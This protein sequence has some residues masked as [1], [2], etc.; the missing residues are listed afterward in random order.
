MQDEF[1]TGRLDAGAEGLKVGELL[2]PVLGIAEGRVMQHD[3]AAEAAIAE[4]DQL[5]L[6]RSHLPFADGATGEAGRCG[7]GSGNADQRDVA[8]QPDEGE[9]VVAL[10]RRFD[11]AAV[12]QIR[13]GHVG[14]PLTDGL[15]PIQRDIGVVIAGYDRDLVGRAEAADP[16]CCV[17]ELA[18]ERDVDDVAGHRDVV[19]RGGGH[20]LGQGLEDWCHIEVLPVQ[21]PGQE[22]K[23]A[24]VQQLADAAVRQRSD[25]GIRQMRQCEHFASRA[26]SLYMPPF[27][28]P[29][30]AGVK[31]S[32]IR[33]RVRVAG[34]FL[35]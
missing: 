19:G 12:A 30:A 27:M 2:A 10:E 24:L 21:G 5:L 33:S 23:D 28:W 4:R 6:Q 7:A 14:R 18:G 11:G 9:L 29:A 1:C 34:S 35:A 22:A 3:D 25:M 8:A 17:I 15:L 16:A 31:K 13:V 20:V 32:L 26:A